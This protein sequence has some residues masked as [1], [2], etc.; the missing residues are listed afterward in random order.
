MVA[1]TAMVST[2][3]LIDTVVDGFNDRLKMKIER[4]SFSSF[5]L[6]AEARG[7]RMEV[8]SLMPTENI[9]A[10]VTKSRFPSNDIVDTMSYFFKQSLY[11]RLGVSG[12][13]TKRPGLIIEEPYSTCRKTRA[14]V[15]NWLGAAVATVVRE[16]VGREIATF[17]QRVLI[18]SNP[19][20]AE[21]I[22]LYVAKSMSLHRCLNVDRLMLFFFFS[23][24]TICLRDAFR[25]VE[26]T[27]DH[28]EGADRVFALDAIAA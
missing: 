21:Q 8:L 2:R 10:A 18:A 22:G 16:R 15:E 17:N 4:S 19:L 25:S 12:E 9:K 13:P 20:T 27:D 14:V 5:E 3:I 23:C 28:Q 11:C 24:L 26:S 7:I 6:I 1:M